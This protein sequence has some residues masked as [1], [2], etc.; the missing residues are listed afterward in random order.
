VSP[1]RGFRFPILLGT[2]SENTLSSKSRLKANIGY[3]S[4]WLKLDNF[5]ACADRWPSYGAEL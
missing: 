5:L 1:R 3:E 4:G 2:I